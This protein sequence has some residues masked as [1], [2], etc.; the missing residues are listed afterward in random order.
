[1]KS[2]ALLLFLPYFLFNTDVEHTSLQNNLSMTSN[3]TTRTI[4]LIRHAKSSWDHPE[5][6]DI[7]RPLGERGIKDAPLMGQK[8]KEKKITFDLIIASPS[9]RTRETIRAICKEIGYPEDKIVWDS[10]LYL[11]SLSNLKRIINELDNSINTVALVGHNPCTTSAV[12][13][14]QSDEIIDNVPT[15][16]IVSISFCCETWKKVFEK[17]G[18]LNYFIYPKKYQL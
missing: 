3:E 6:S 8:L 12:N 11:S 10:S 18:H 15:T 1:M 9:Q 14:F 5:L 17:N 2:I 16:G 7:Q 4:V 13:A